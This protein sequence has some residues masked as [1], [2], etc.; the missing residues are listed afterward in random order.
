MPKLT[1]QKRTRTEFQYLT[2]VKAPSLITD[3]TC[4]LVWT[5][6]W[7]GDSFLFLLRPLRKNFKKVQKGK[8]RSFGGDCVW[9]P[10]HYEP[11]SI[12]TP[13][14]NI[15]MQPTAPRSPTSP[16]HSH[17]PPRLLCCSFPFL[18]PARC[19]MPTPNFELRIVFL[20]H[21]LRWR[22]T[23]SKNTRISSSSCCAENADLPCCR[24]KNL[25]PWPLPR[26]GLLRHL[27]AP[28]TSSI[29]FFSSMF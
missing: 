1:D 6:P 23:T 29:S 24:I 15:P 8:E 4:G 22:S 11:P 2:F 17:S 19:P 28:C 3:V 10:W 21:R 7:H 27:W 20:R 5:P 26:E 18:P 12:T 9:Y 16:H 14:W 25:W 13:L